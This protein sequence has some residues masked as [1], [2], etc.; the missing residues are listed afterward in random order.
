MYI[1]IYAY[2]REEG[3]G[4]RFKSSVVRFG[5]QTLPVNGGGGVSVGTAVCYGPGAISMK[6]NW[7]QGAPLHLHTQLRTPYHSGG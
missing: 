2:R 1:I 7:V 3:T 5:N 6:E 4:G